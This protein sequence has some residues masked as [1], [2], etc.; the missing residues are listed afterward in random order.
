MAFS[1]NL[2]ITLLVLTIFNFIFFTKGKWEYIFSMLLV[3]LL[4]IAPDMV[5]LFSGAPYSRPGMFNISIVGYDVIIICLFIFSKGTIR[6]RRMDRRTVLTLLTGMYAMFMIRFIVD[7]FD[8]LSNKMLDN[9]LLPILLAFLVV[10]YM[11]LECFERCLRVFYVSILINAVIASA[12]VLL[13]RS[14]LFHEYYYDTNAWYQSVYNSTQWG[15]PMRGTAFLG[16][17]LYNGMYYLLAI[18]YL[19]N[20]SW[21]NKRLSRSM[22]LLVLA[23][24]I[25]ATNSRGVLIFFAGYTLITIL[26]RR[27]YGKLVVLTA[28][29]TILLA[30]VD[31]ETLYLSVFSRDV[32]GRSLMHRLMG[33]QAFSKIPLHT[34]LVGTGYN[35]TAEVLSAAGMVGNFENAYLIVLLENGVFGFICWLGILLTLY[36]RGMITR[37]GDLNAKGMI[38]GMLLSCLGLACTGN[39]F[40]DPGTLN[41]T[42][43]MIMA[44]SRLL[45]YANREKNKLP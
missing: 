27:N 17:P 13:G 28:I 43:W 33:L 6:I 9:M 29:A 14:W 12:E 4:F 24:G 7:G 10:S 44:F 40:G 35:N 2:L 8:I 11:P 3:L 20:I 38:N 37:L 18:V 41:Y 1:L 34:I 31:L 15:I 23:C 5:G 45:S 19:Y 22:E 21:K 30:C 32:S 25:L 16:H 39:Y 42:L 36:R 26:R